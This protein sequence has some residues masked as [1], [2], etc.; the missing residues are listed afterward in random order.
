M[1]KKEIKTLSWNFINH[2][3]NL[4]ALRKKG[5]LL[6]FFAFIVSMNKNFLKNK[7]Y[8][9][10]HL[11]KKMTMLKK[12]GCLITNNNLGFF[13]KLFLDYW[14]I[15]DK[16]ITNKNYKKLWRFQI[17]M[18]SNLKLIKTHFDY[19]QRGMPQSLGVIPQVELRV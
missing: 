11:L 16:T 18:N 15:K 14:S 10:M 9:L 7:K 8:T 12:F 17:K 5:S 4:S 19:Y 6:S 13:I 2:F 1:Q 3:I